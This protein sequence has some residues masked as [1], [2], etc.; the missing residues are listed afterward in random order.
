[1]YFSSLLGLHAAKG[2]HTNSKEK[3]YNQQAACSISNEINGAMY[4]PAR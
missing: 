2:Q 3:G 4:T 1:M